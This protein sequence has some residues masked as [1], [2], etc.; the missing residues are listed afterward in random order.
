MTLKALLIITP[1]LIIV[2]SALL[3]IPMSRVADDI[4]WG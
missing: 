4:N 2:L 3:S 1:I